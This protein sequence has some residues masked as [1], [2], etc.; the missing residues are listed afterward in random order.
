M[1]QLVFGFIILHYVNYLFKGKFNK[2]KRNLI[3]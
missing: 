1:N 2:K 3:N